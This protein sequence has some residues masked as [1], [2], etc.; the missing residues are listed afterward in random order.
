MP[1]EKIENLLNLALDA[2]GEEREKSLELEVGFD[3]EEKNWEVIVKFSGTE[4]ELRLLL[5]QNFPEEYDSIRLTSLRNEYAILVL[6]EHIVERVAALNEIEYMEKPKLLFFA[7]NN[8]K[9][10]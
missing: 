4:E 2:S 7:V 1:N 6:P 8:G 9:R 3:R 10:E 5:R